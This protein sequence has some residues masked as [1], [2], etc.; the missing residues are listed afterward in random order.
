MNIPIIHHIKNIIEMDILKSS[1]K[2]V[3]DYVYIGQK[4]NV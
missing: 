4:V 2:K 1:E 3:G